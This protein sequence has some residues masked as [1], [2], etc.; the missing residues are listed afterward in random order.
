MT[1]GR[2]TDPSIRALAASAFGRSLRAARLK[3]GM[4]QEELAHQ[5]GLDRTYPSLLERGCRQP[6]VG[7]AFALAAALRLDP[8]ELITS[9]AEQIRT[10]ASNTTLG[11]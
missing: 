7:V 2:M 9:T 5:A 10:M 1:A 11:V 6:T 8:V 4:S 3:V